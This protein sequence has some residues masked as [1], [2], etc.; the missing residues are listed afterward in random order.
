MQQCAPTLKR[1][2][3]ELGGN[4]P[5]I[6]FADAD[7]NAAVEGAVASK[8]RNA[9]QTCVCANRIYVHES[10]A[11]EFA[12]KLAAA[13]GALKLGDG[14]VK[15]TQVGPMISHVAVERTEAFVASAVQRG[16]TLLTGGK[17]GNVGP[18]Y[19]KGYFFQPTVLSNVP[20]DCD[21]MLK[22]I[23]GPVVRKNLLKALIGVRLFFYL[24]DVCLPTVDF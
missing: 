9:G 21:I 2:S 18:G 6:V 5:F 12:Q 15:G 1:M 14:A 7:I 13:A 16:A 23:F 8:F 11:A 10:V 19:E 17:R 22:E 4:A 24:Y 3:L 20:F